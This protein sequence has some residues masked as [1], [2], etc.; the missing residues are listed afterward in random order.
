LDEIKALDPDRLTPLDALMLIKQ[1]REKLA[2][3]GGSSEG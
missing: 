2:G 1:W 3:G